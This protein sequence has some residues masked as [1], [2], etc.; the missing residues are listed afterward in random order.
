MVFNKRR[1]DTVQLSTFV[2]TVIIFHFNT[3]VAVFLKLK[4]LFAFSMFSS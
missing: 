1:T 2:L 3:V 4:C